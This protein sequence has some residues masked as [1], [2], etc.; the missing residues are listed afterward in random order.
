MIA[1]EIIVKFTENNSFLSQVKLM[2]ARTSTFRTAKTMKSRYYV[3]K[4]TTLYV[5]YTE[6]KL[7]QRAF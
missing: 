4:S 2:E 6:V 5:E 7:V 1:T 3:R